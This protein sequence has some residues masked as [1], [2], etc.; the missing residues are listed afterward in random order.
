M[1][2]ILALMPIPA[3]AQGTSSLHAGTV[4]IENDKEKD[5]FSQLRC[6]CGTCARDL[7]STCACGTADETRE[8]LRKK[9]N[10]GI[11]RD[12]IIAEYAAEYGSESLAVPP[13]TGVFRALYIVPIA[14]AAGSIGG[15]AF[16]VRRWKEKTQV[17]NAP[18]KAAVAARDAY[19]DR[20][21]E[22]LRDL[23]G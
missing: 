13:N 19:D 15:A 18:K 1:G 22:E 4:H 7:L 20:L 6:M 11:A 21:D 10:A 16:L 3:F 8:R 12:A 17:Q 14:L 23:D 9:I 5:V 2:V